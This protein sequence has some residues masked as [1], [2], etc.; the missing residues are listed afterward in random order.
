MV[1]SERVPTSSSHDFVAGPSR[2]RGHGWPRHPNLPYRHFRAHTITFCYHLSDVMS[3]SYRCELCIYKSLTSVS[4]SLE[5]I[6]ILDLTEHSLGFNRPPTS[7]HQPLFTGQQFSGHSSQFIIAMVDLYSPGFA[8]AFIAHA[9][10]R[11]VGA[12]LCLI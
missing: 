3:N 4:E 11:T 6:V 7:M 1:P 9:P 5:V 2:S 8:L 12:V 10:E